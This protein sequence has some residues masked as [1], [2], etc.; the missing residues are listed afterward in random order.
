MNQVEI[1]MFSRQEPPC[2]GC[3][4]MKPIVDG[5]ANARIVD[6]TDEPELAMKYN[7]RSLPMFVK[8]VDGYLDGQLVGAMPQ[9]KLVRW[10]SKA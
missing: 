10:A 5:I 6:V 9:S 8:L 3:I 1:I 4:A 2:S 7:V